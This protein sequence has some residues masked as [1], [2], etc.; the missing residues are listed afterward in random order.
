MKKNKFILV[1]LFIFFMLFTLTSCQSSENKDTIVE[2]KITEE[3]DVNFKVY[4]K[5]QS[6]YNYNDVNYEVVALKNG[7]EVKKIAVNSMDLTIEHNK[8]YIYSGSFKKENLDFDSIEVVNYTYEIDTFYNT[9]NSFII[10]MPII[11]VILSG[12]VFYFLY[13]GEPTKNT[14]SV[15]G[16]TSVIGLIGLMAMLAMINYVGW[17]SIAFMFG[18]AAI[19]FLTGF[20]AVKLKKK[21]YVPREVLEKEEIKV[22]DNIID[23]IN[24]TETT[25]DVDNNVD[26][27]TDKKEGE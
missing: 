20:M 1:C 17:V 8:T 27:F 3:N 14:D 10:L 18:C 21:K 13:R 24:I 9:Y 12:I 25:S 2:Y 15:A 22:I 5:N 7:E 16:K 11:T 4:L 26:E 6:I 19:I 23:D